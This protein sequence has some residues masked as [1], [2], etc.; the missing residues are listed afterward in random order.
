M[1]LHKMENNTSDSNTFQLSQPVLPNTLQ[2]VFSKNK[3]K[4]FNFKPEC[5]REEDERESL[6]HNNHCHSSHKNNIRIRKNTDRL[7]ATESPMGASTTP[8]GTDHLLQHLPPKPS[9]HRSFESTSSKSHFMPIENPI[10]TSFSNVNP[11]INIEKSRGSTRVDAMA[12]GPEPK[13][14]YPRPQ[15]RE[16]GANKQKQ[17]KTSLPAMMPVTLELPL[18]PRDRFLYIYIYIYI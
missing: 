14:S 13:L 10:Q 8:E 18:K 7:F 1:S 4:L 12:S 17:R 11:Q 15:L 6:L 5:I 16:S 9:N 2:S 3:R